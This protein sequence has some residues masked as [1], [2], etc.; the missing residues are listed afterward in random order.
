MAARRARAAPDGSVTVAQLQTALRSWLDA[1]QSRD[2][3]Q[4]LKPL[5]TGPKAIS[6]KT[7]PEVTTMACFSPAARLLA[8]VCRNGVLPTLKLVSALQELHLQSPVNYT[9]EPM[10]VWAPNTGEK[11]RQCMSKYRLVKNDPT[12]KLVLLKKAPVL[13]CA[14]QWQMKEGLGRGSGRGEG[15]MWKR[16]RCGGGG[17]SVGWASGRGD[18]GHLL[19]DGTCDSSLSTCLL[20]VE[21]TQA[22]VEAV[23]SVL[24]HLDLDSSSP[25]GHES[26]GAA[27]GS[28]AE[29]HAGDDVDPELEAPWPSH[30]HRLTSPRPHDHCPTSCCRSLIRPRPP[31][32]SCPT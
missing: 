21:A 15:R 26:G 8:Q 30:H 2:I 9:H 19:A 16:G 6:W 22:Q 25:R 28:H 12:A 3:H 29:W 11:M 4:L 18:W 7:A 13:A 32:D 17:C 10:A 31:Y 23:E 1:V 20:P 27:T 5:R 24:E 14:V